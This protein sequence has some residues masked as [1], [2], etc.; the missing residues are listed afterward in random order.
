MNVSF[1]ENRA[2]LLEWETLQVQR[3]VCENWLSE[4]Q[5]RRVQ[6]GKQ[7]NASLKGFSARDLRGNP[8]TIRDLPGRSSDKDA[9]VK[10]TGV[11]FT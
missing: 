8:S 5:G 6:S 10:N 2:G 3:E 1:P 4:E 9:Q 7:D 11:C